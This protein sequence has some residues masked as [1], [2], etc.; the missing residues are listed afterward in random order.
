VGSKYEK[1]PMLIDTMV[2]GSAIKYRSKRSATADTTSND[3]TI[4]NI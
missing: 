2:N 4:K 1:V 3:K